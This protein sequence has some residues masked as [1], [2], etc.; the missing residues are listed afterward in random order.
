MDFIN[1]LHVVMD[2][3]TQFLQKWNFKSLVLQT[4]IRHSSLC[5][6]DSLKNH[7][8][9]IVFTKLNLQVLELKIFLVNAVVL[10]GTAFMV[11]LSESQ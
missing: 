4:P 10:Q 1:I 9:K 5:F 11:V 7:G 8:L 3:D 2:H 6:A